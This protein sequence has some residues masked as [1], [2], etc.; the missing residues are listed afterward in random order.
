M[1]YVLSWLIGT[2]DGVL[3][4]TLKQ[5][6]KMLYVLSWLIGTKDGVLSSA[7]KQIIKMLYVLSGS[8]LIGSLG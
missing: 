4:S 7:L 3:S 6:I 8:W 5:I 2:K 1:L